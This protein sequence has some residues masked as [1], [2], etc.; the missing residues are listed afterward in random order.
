[1]ATQPQDLLAVEIGSR[2]RARRQ[3]LDYS[4][5]LVAGLV[6]VS[7]SSLI[8]YE[9]GRQIPRSDTLRALAF[10]LGLGVDT[11]YPE[12]YAPFV[13]EEARWFASRSNVGPRP[14]PAST[15]R[16]QERKKVK[17]GRREGGI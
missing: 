17:R 16:T 1:M 12:D 14:A 13:S 2:L 10:V 5:E 4:L 9:T 11:L 8:L 7:K 3:E 6:D 15:R